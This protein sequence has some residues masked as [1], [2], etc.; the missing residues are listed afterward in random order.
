MIM[1][2]D[3]KEAQTVHSGKSD[4]QNNIKVARRF[5]TRDWNKRSEILDLQ[6]LV[7]N[8][9]HFWY[10]KWNQRDPNFHAI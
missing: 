10:A 2:I 7:L 9:S 4:S 5:K 6:V 1:N 8:L 3:L